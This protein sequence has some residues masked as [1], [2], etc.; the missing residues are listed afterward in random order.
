MHDSIFTPAV[1]GLNLLV[2]VKLL[3]M[4]TRKK[5]SLTQE[6]STLIALLQSLRNE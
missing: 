5:E 4:L 1:N 2:R 6:I 3:A